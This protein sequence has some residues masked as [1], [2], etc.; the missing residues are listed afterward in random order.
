[1]TWRTFPPVVPDA[2]ANPARPLRIVKTVEQLKVDAA[3]KIAASR[4]VLET[5]GIDF[6]GTRIKT[7]RESQATLNAAM[8]AVARNPLLEIDWKGENGW[9][10]LG[11]AEV[12]AISDAVIAHVQ[13]CFTAEKDKLVALDALETADEVRAFDCEVT[14]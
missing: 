13:A 5:A 2:A 11:K 3:Q 14:L 12:E 4:Y 8:T 10:K 1:M 7:D 6:Y 9:A